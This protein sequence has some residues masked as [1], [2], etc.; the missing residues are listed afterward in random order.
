MIDNKPRD[1]AD[2][3]ASRP[4]ERAATATE[5]AKAAD[6]AAEKAAET[7]QKRAEIDQQYRDD[8]AKAGEKRAKALAKL[9]AHRG[10]IAEVAWD[11]TKREE[12]PLYNAVAPDHRAKLDTAVQTIRESGNA[13]IVGLEAF[14]ERVKELLAEEAE[15]EG[16]P[17]KVAAAAK[18]VPDKA[19][20][21]ANK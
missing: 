12:D 11:E 3:D 1:E 20:E 16:T 15:A 17:S 10:N 9:P 18:A 7:E 5:M 6:K 4:A 19:T 21:K 2:K 14:E 8:V 13:D